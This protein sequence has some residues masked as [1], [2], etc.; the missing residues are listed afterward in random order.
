MAFADRAEAG[1]R[2]ANA[3]DDYQGE[4]VVVVG[5][6]RGGVEVAFPIARHLDAPLTVVLIRKIGFPMH[7]ELAMGAIVDG[8]EP[9]T[10][11][12]EDVLRR[13]HIP[14]IIFDEVAQRELAEIHRRQKIY[15]RDRSSV[16]LEG[17]VVI[18]VDDGIATGATV[19]AAIAGIKARKPR[20]IVLAVPVAA[21]DSLE[22]IRAEVDEVICL[23]PLHR[24]GAISLSYHHFPQLT[25]N[26][27]IALLDAA[28]RPSTP[29]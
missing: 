9:I 11:K 28:E 8:D 5:L 23:E 19:R 20:K 25:D 10:V 3:L 24:L 4:D 14:K 26:D 29:Q 22:T 12:N 1:A 15:L 17:R 2:L 21:E 18:I 6:P 7:P 13:G 27:V 16:P